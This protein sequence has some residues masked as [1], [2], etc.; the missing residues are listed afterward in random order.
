MCEYRL[1]EAF[2]EEDSLI[3]AT[4]ARNGGAWDLEAIGQGFSG[5]LNTLVDMYQ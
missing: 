2:T 3:I 5:G 1:N 4:I